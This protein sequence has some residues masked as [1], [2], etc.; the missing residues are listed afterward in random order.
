MATLETQY[1]NWLKENEPITY[2]EWLEKFSE[3]HHL[4]K[5]K[6]PTMENKQTAV[7]WLIEEI[8]KNMEFIPVHIQEQAKAMEK[9]QIIDANEDS[10]TNEL[11]EFLTGEQYYNETYGK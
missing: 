9:K 1:K 11:G 10:S 8:H 6:E 2:S 5:L 7:E 3:I 4:D